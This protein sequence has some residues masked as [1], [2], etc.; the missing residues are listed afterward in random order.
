MNQFLAI[1]FAP[2]LIALVVAFA[3]CVRGTLYG[4]S[5]V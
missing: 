4:S 1:I 5:E 2:S 3:L